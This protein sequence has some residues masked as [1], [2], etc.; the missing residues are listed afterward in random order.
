MRWGSTVAAARFRGPSAAAIASVGT[1]KEQ[2][3][4]RAHL[5][6]GAAGRSLPASSSKHAAWVDAPAAIQDG[7][8]SKGAP[9]PLLAGPAFLGIVAQHHGNGG[10]AAAVRALAM[11]EPRQWWS[12]GNGWSCGNGGAMAMVGAAAGRPFVVCR[13][14]Y[15]RAPKDET[16]RLWSQS[17]K[18]TGDGGAWRWRASA[19]VC[20]KKACSPTSYDGPSQQEWGP[21][22]NN[23]PHLNLWVVLGQ[24]DAGQAPR[25]CACPRW[26]CPRC[27]MP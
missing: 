23:G 17:F 18:F 24:L 26:P 1:Q 12:H 22:L 19:W 10:T 2:G 9:G 4:R 5:R 13:M 8:E 14:P 27:A 6:R 15:V 21:S 3:G 16:V 25:L 20:T 7:G 11:V